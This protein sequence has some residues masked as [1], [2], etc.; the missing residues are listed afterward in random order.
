MRILNGRRCFLLV[1]LVVLVVVELP[2]LPLPLLLP[3]LP[4]RQNECG[5]IHECTSY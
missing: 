5:F 2:L 3:L 1:V 4:L